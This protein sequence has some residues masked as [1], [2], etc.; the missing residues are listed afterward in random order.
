MR[1]TCDLLRR[2]WD[3]HG[4]V[5]VPVEPVRD[6]R[7]WHPADR[8]GTLRGDGEVTVRDVVGRFSSATLAGAPLT[9]PDDLTGP[10]LLLFAYRQRQQRDVDTWI[11]AARGTRIRLLE[12]P[13]L[14]RRWLPGRRFIDGGMASN[15]DRA[16]REQ[17]MCVYTHVARFRRD[18]LGVSST[19]V[20]AALVDADGRVA[21]HALGPADEAGTATL[22][23]AI[24]DLAADT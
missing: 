4:I 12:V 21:W 8:T 5:A 17:T 11:A 13:V 24:T 23:A 9:V 7:H 15:M 2:S 19:R 10:T 14:G 3:V 16:T 1:R 20:L 22:R 18:V 6:L